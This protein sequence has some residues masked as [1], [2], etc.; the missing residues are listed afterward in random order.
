MIIH[1]N[2]KPEMYYDIGNQITK[3]KILKGLKPKEELREESIKRIRKKRKHYQYQR[4][5]RKK[6]GSKKVWVFSVV[7]L[8]HKVTRKLIVT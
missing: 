7:G 5:T 3:L 8:S 2:Y 6:K 4:N 1:K